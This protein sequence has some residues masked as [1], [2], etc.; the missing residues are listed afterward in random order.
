M[1][2]GNLVLSPGLRLEKF[3]ILFREPL[4]HQTAHFFSSHIHAY[5]Y[6]STVHRDGNRIIFPKRDTGE[7]NRVVTLEWYNSS[8]PSRMCRCFWHW[9][10]S[11]SGLVVHLHSYIPHT[12]YILPRNEVKVTFSYFWSTTHN[13]SKGN[14]WYEFST[15]YRLLGKLKSRCCVWIISFD[16]GGGCIL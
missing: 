1:E 3:Q 4:W 2:N 7:R 5:Y 16:A 15:Y 11:I 8:T 10:V 14:C 12:Y 6:N 13:M 9:R